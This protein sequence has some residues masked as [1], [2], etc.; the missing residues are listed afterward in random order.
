[1]TATDLAAVVIAVAALGVTAVAVL[2]IVQVRRATDELG[3]VLGS[4]RT[5]MDRTAGRLERQAA[6]IEGELERVDGLI[7]SAERVSARADTL[8]RVTYGA[9]ARP[10]IRTAAVVKG[11]TRAARLL[12][13]GQGDDIDEQAG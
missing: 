12:R 10:V 3:E 11:T 4:L 13:R 9:V 6:T 8:S 1:M 7:E 5:D 2:L